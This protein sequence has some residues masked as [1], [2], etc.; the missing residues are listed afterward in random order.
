[1]AGLSEDVQTNKRNAGMDST[2]GIEE[3]QTKKFCFDQEYGSRFTFNI[4]VT[5]NLREKAF[6]CHL[7]IETDLKGREFSA[8]Q[9]QCTVFALLCLGYCRRCWQYSIKCFI[10]VYIWHVAPQTVRLQEDVLHNYE[11][12]SPLKSRRL[13]TSSMNKRDL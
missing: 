9:S 1:M 13:Y 11:K 2:T 10:R 7:T 3:E 8:R 6:F 4:I 5:G 12:N